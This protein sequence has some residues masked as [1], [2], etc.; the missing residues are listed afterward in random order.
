MNFTQ[1]AEAF[2]RFRNEQANELFIVGVFAVQARD[3]KQ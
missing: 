3:I 2:N 1:L